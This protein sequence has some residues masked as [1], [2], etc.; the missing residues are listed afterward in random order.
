MKFLDVN[1]Y[2]MQMKYFKEGSN[3]QFTSVVLP[4]MSK[5]GRQN[6]K[7]LT[8]PKRSQDFEVELEYKSLPDRSVISMSVLELYGRHPSLVIVKPQWQ[9][10]KPN[11]QELRVPSPI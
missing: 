6:F 11:F 9:S 4:S 10:S 7:R 3:K 1:A 5:L 8:F 2:D